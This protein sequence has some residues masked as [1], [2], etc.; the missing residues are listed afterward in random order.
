MLSSSSSDEEDDDVASPVRP[1]PVQKKRIPTE[2]LQKVLASSPAKE[3]GWPPERFRRAVAAPRSPER[4]PRSPQ[5]TQATLHA[6]V[7]A[8]ERMAQM[9]NAQHT[10]GAGTAA[11]RFSFQQRAQRMQRPCRTAPGSEG[12]R[13]VIEAAHA[14]KAAAAWPEESFQT[15][16]DDLGANCGLGVTHHMQ[17]ILDEAAPGEDASP[18]LGAALEAALE[19]AMQSLSVCQSQQSSLLQR[20]GMRLKAEFRQR[21]A[22]LEADFVAR[23]E[24][25]SGE[26]RCLGALP[27]FVASYCT[28]AHALC[29]V[30]AN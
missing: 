18:E 29:V 8:V 16:G 14:A 15:T 12:A 11:E 3:R 22:E 25:L 7:D 6:R 27:R 2:R 10:S 19:T 9:Q 23:A 4:A 1:P 5:A 13:A 21:L 24:A 30:A 26:V 28:R 20:E 17:S